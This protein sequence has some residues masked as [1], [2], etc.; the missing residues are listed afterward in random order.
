VQDL[1][2]Q[3]AA[4]LLDVSARMRVLD[5]CAAPGGKA[6]HLLELAEAEVVAVDSDAARLERIRENLERLRL[7]RR[8]IQLVHADAG[9][10]STWWD[11]VPYDRV[12]LDVPCTASGVVRRHP[13]GKWRHR[14]GDVEHF[15][16]EQ[17]RLLD[18]CWPL[19]ARRGTLLYATCS[20]F[21]AENDAPIERFLGRHDDA[22]RETLSFPSATAHRNGQ[23]LPSPEGAGHNQDG[24]FYALLRKR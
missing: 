5:A 22:L 20:V 12:L 24:F 16:R 1:A 7:A 23:L 6:T 17:A 21:A 4:P 18:A 10:P 3:L 15:A 2:A 8:A 13:D 11:G 19:L 9:A 14:A